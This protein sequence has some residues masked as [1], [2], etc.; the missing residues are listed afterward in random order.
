MRAGHRATQDGG[1]PLGAWARR[2]GS[3]GEGVSSPLCP[4][5]CDLGHAPST[6]VSASL[7]WGKTQGES[8][9]S[10]RWPRSRLAVRPGR[11]SAAAQLLRERLCPRGGAKGLS[12]HSMLPHAGRVRGAGQ[13]AALMLFHAHPSEPASRSW[14]IWLAGTVCTDS[15]RGNTSQQ[16][17]RLGNVGLF[18]PL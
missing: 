14:D 10:P 6:L 11:A 4:V 18:N 13:W 5:L 16:Q 3:C 8:S 1:H 12:G 15:L 9:T 7:A 17:R 2:G